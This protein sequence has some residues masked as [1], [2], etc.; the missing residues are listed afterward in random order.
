M[1]YIFGLIVVAIFFGV[2]HY[3]TELT[4]S[5]KATTTAIVLA[6]V[7][8]AVSYNAYSNAQGEK[9]LDA[10]NRY[11]LGQTITCEGIDIN[12]TNFSL[13]VGTYTFIGKK[14]T[15]YFNKMVS[16]AACK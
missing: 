8:G 16:A 7:L 11:N 12:N 13:S 15:P 3:F 6:V 10:V 4:R 9:M 2:L 5:Q 14:D 1:A